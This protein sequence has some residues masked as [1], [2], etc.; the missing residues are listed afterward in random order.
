[1]KR[2]GSIVLSV[3]CVIV[4]SGGC[5]RRNAKGPQAYSTAKVEQIQNSDIDMLGEA[6]MKQKGGASYEFF[7]DLMPPLR[8][9]DANF[10]HYP[11]TLSAPASTQK[12][13]LVGDGS[14]VNALVRSRAWINE[15]GK[16]VT[17]Y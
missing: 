13:R 6:A 10:K 17:F 2:T 5:A 3:L 8:Y 14:A 16:P 9:T 1:M 4:V 11:I 7:R 12:V 15:T